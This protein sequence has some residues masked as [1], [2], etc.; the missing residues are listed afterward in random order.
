MTW[1][2]DIH[3]KRHTPREAKL[4]APSHTWAM[5]LSQLDRQ[6]GRLRI[7]TVAMPDEDVPLPV[8]GELLGYVERIFMRRPSA[9]DVLAGPQTSVERL[10]SLK[11][12]FPGVRVAHHATSD[13]RIVLLEPDTIYVGADFGRSHSPVVT[14]GVRSKEAHEWYVDSCFSRLWSQARVI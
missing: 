4:Y 1:K 5:K 8:N 10:E 7:A 11:R 6:A 12:R 3:G 13:V 9:I 14:L 2:D